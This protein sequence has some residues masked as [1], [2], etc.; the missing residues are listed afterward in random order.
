MKT[1]TYKVKFY[2][3]NQLVNYNHHGFGALGPKILISKEWMRLSDNDKLLMV[4]C[5]LIASVNNG[6]IENDVEYLQKACGLSFTP[7]LN[8]LI[9]IGFLTSEKS[10]GFSLE[11]SD[12][13]FVCGNGKQ[14]TQNGKP[15]KSE[16]FV[17]RNSERTELILNPKEK[18]LRKEKEKLKKEKEKKQKKETPL[19]PKS[20][21]NVPELPDNVNPETWQDFEEMRKKLR[22][23]LTDRAKKLAIGALQKIES[24]HG[25]DPNHVLEQS[26][27][28]GWQGLFPVKPD[29]LTQ[30]N[31]HGRFE[32]QDYNAETEGFGKV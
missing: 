18:K 32:T 25:H 16:D 7:N 6:V 17:S 12:D 13:D 24:S 31:S 2:D 14:E 29:F 11:R 21:S 20:R 23:P 1:E 27:L 5:L 15:L 8:T 22:K 10:E 3:E 28:N 26:I 19:P 30:G 9:D 4:C